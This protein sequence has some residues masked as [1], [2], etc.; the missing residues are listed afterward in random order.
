V[1]TLTVI[2]LLY[3]LASEL[4]KRVM[5]ARLGRVAA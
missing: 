2:T 1:L 4:L 3:L 5:F